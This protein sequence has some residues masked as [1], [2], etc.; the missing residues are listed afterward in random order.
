MLAQCCVERKAFYTKA[1]GPRMGGVAKDKHGYIP[2]SVTQQDIE[3]AKRKDSSLCVVAT[4]IARSIP[5]AT[6]IAVDIQCIQFTDPDGQ[7]QSYLTP[8][9]VQGYIIAFDAGD[10]LH[11][12][13]FRL[14]P[15]QRVQV[16]RRIT[17]EAGKVQARAKAAERRAALRAATLDSSDSATPAERRVAAEKLG[18][19]KAER[20][21]VRAAYDTQAWTATDD[22]SLPPAPPRMSKRKERAYG[23]RLLRVNRPENA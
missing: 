14:R 3:Q 6:R 15:D 7:R 19:A 2:V 5:G 10:D 12:F 22:T 9:S 21:A 4:G 11:P 23:M 8:P 18:A 17:T 1:K 13:N 20:D 16:R